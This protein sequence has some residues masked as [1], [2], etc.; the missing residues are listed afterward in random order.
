MTFTLAPW[1]DTEKWLDPFRMIEDLQEEMNRLFDLSLFGPSRS[2]GLFE[3]A[4]SP[5]IDMHESGENILVKADLP[6]MNKDDIEVYVQNNTLVI[7]GKK[8][9]EK[10][11]SEDGYVRKERFYGN[12]HRA[13]P[14]PAE[15]DTNNV[16]ATYKNGVLELVFNKKEEAKAKQIKVEVK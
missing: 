10:E 4:W 16:K 15:V 9:E 1:R 5:A 2:T 14:L 7:K 3:G 13:I 6:G 11:F 12:F 8:E